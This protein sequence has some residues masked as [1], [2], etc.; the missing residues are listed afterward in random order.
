MQSKWTG[1]SGVLRYLSLVQLFVATVSL[2][3]VA[4]PIRTQHIDL[5]APKLMT[6]IFI[7]LT[8]ERI[9]KRKV[10]ASILK[11]KVAGHY[12]PSLASCNSWR[13]NL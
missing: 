10:K 3:E 5:S 7:F 6:D 8:R 1:R 11:E 2:D 13:F 9:E 12:A 4:V